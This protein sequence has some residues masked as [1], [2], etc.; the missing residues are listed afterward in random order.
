MKQYQSRYAIEEKQNFED[1]SFLEIHSLP[2]LELTLGSGLSNVGAFLTLFFEVKKIV[3][4]MSRHTMLFFI[5]EGKRMQS[6]KS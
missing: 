1:W 6:S 5:H 2:S 4:D 3:R